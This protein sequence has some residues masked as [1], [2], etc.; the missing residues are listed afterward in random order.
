MYK[1]LGLTNIKIFGD[2]NGEKFHINSQR[3]I[4]VGTKSKNILQKER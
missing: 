1:H 3:I 4:V 2:Y